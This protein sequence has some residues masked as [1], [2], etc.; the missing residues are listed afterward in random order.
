MSRNVAGL[1]ERGTCLAW[2]LG[3][4]LMVRVT[5]NLDDMI[6]LPTWY[7]MFR[8]VLVAQKMSRNVAW[9]AAPGTCFA[10]I[11]SSESN[12]VCYIATTWHDS[13]NELILMSFVEFWRYKKGHERLQ[14]LHTRR[15][16]GTVLAQKSNNARY[17]E[18]GWHDTNIDVVWTSFI[19]FWWSKRCHEMLQG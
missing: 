6:L 17:I 7:N 2:F 11:C 14:C 8:R 5:L 15:I 19:E 1:A 3:R 9:L 4:N 13:T 18:S 16:F 10:R 12:G